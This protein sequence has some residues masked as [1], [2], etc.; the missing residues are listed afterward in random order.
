MLRLE[1]VVPIAHQSI[2]QPTF[3]QFCDLDILWARRPESANDVLAFKK[4][5]IS[6]PNSTISLTLA[7]YF[8]AAFTSTC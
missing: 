2:P 8:N 3:L 5:Q 4:N 6:E 1:E 7:N